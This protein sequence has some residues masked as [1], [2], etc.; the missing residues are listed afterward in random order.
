MNDDITFNYKLKA[1]YDAN[2][3]D[4]KAVD[5][6]IKVANNN[7]FNASAISFVLL[8]SGIMKGRVSFQINFTQFGD[9]KVN[10]VLLYSINILKCIIQC[11]AFDEKSFYNFEENN[12]QIK[13]FPKGDSILVQLLIN[14][15][16]H[17]ETLV[18]S[19]SLLKMAAQFYKTV[20]SDCRQ[21]HPEL[22]NNKLFRDNL[23]FFFI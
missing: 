17:A 7:H 5:S 3:S 6:I 1:S 23:P 8:T 21:T 20:L 18:E 14:E 13:F 19:L 15:K 16:V 9:C 10:S 4:Q 11:A 12:R 2:V 22:S